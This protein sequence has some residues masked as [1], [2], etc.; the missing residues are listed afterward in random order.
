MLERALAIEEREY[1]AEHAEVASTLVSLGAH[2][3][4]RDEA[5]KA[6]GLLERALAIEERVLGKTHGDVAPTLGNLGQCY[7]DLGLPTRASELLER[8]LALEERDRGRSD[9]EVARTLVALG[10]CYGDLGDRRRQKELQERALA[11]FEKKSGD[12]K[13]SL[14]VAACLVSLGDCVGCLGDAK[15]GKDMIERAHGIEK[16]V[17]RSKNSVEAAATLAAL[18]VAYQRLG[19]YP[20]ARDLLER[21]LKLEEREHGPHHREVAAAKSRDLLE[22]ALAID[23]REYGRDHRAVAP[24]LNNLGIAYGR[25]GDVDKRRR[26]IDRANAIKGAGDAS[27]SERED[28]AGPLAPLTG[29]APPPPASGSP[30]WDLAKSLRN[31]D[32]RVVREGAPQLP[33]LA[34][35]A[36]LAPLT[37]MA[38][39]PPVDGSP[40]AR[41][42]LVSP[43]RGIG[44]QLLS[45]SGGDR[46][47]ERHLRD[48]E[49]EQHR[50]KTL[51]KRR[52]DLEEALKHEQRRH[53]LHHRSV[54]SVLVDLG[55]CGR[56]GRRAGR[57]R[58]PGTRFE[59]LRGAAQGR[60]GGLHA[61]RR[62]DVDGPG[63]R[64]REARR[65]AEAARLL[66]ASEDA[67]RAHGRHHPDVA[68]A[69]VN[70]GTAYG[71]LGDHRRHREHI[72]HALRIR[73]K[74]FG[75]GHVEVAH[76]CVAL[77]AAQAATQ[78]RKAQAANLER[79]LAIL[80]REY[81]RDGAATAGPSSGPR[82]TSSSASAASAR[83]SSRGSAPASPSPGPAS[84]RP[85]DPFV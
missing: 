46:R 31:P 25:L 50:L 35:G 83:R 13:T 44:T 28:A 27:F 63:P 16:R 15:R 24:T 48:R 66:R 78:Q 60:R 80:E 26:L 71:H 72:K 75:A 82:P 41:L 45:A 21:A 1:G 59:H 81:G 4:S 70:L 34:S 33:P 20:T 32:A 67:L 47:G 61:V 77:A 74:E 54:A 7:V 76:T 18:G 55:V 52:D 10:D 14:D 2:Y 19:D 68:I 29:D 53:G 23:Y 69:L 39:P 38:P 11:I 36:P 56:S 6:R 58:P 22:R 5:H 42:P 8:A 30:A 40:G 62:G 51:Q 49:D 12:P 43:G 9:P 3:A 79:A 57:A 73:E 84:S 64:L 17:Y 65:A 37:G 85:N